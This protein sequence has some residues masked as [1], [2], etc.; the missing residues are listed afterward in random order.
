M[1]YFIWQLHLY[2]YMYIS[3]VGKLFT[4]E[5]HIKLGSNKEGLN[6][7]LYFTVKQNL[8][9]TLHYMLYINHNFLFD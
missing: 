9:S 1:V 3:E 8:T 7:F 4:I 6:N 5:G 2:I